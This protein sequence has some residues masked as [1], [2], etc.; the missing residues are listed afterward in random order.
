MCYSKRI[1]MSKQVNIA[2]NSIN[3][4]KVQLRVYQIQVRIFKAKQKNQIEKMDRLQNLLIQNY[5]SKLLAVSK[6]FQVIRIQSKIPDAQKFEIVFRVNVTRKKALQP[7]QIIEQSFKNFWTIQF[8]IDRAT[9]YLILFAIDPQWE[10]RFDYHILDSSLLKT[11]QDIIE[12]CCLRLQNKQ[13]RWLSKIQFEWNLNQIYP[14]ILLNKLKT[15]PQIERFVQ[16]WINQDCYKSEPVLGPLLLNILFSALDTIF[17]SYVK[18]VVFIRYMS[19]FLLFHK[20]KKILR[21]VVLRIYL[22]LQSFY[23]LINLEKSSI[24]D[25]QK[26]FRFLGFQIIQLNR[27]RQTLVK[28]WPDKIEQNKFLLTIRCKLQMNKSVSS[29]EMIQILRPIVLFWANYYQ[30]CDCQIT[31]KRLT[32]LIFQKLRAWCLRR[33]TRS[34][35][36]F[37]LDKYFPKNKIWIFNRKKYKTRW[38]LYG[39]SE[40]K[41]PQLVETFLPNVNWIQK[42][43]FIPVV[44]K[45]SLYNN[46]PYYWLLKRYRFAKYFPILPYVYQNQQGICSI[47]ALQLTPFDQVKIIYRPLR[48]KLFGKKDGVLKFRLVH[49]SCIHQKIK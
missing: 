15:L 45:L 35:K 24:L 7:R 34:S 43:I 2:W 18:D 26:G 28:I 39:R 14:S 49:Q 8:L 11:K 12:A 27:T 37:V 1:F 47:C 17:Q 16:Y 10:A 29:F 33:D 6:V 13:G 25:V 42:K 4:T 31:Y 36:T 19:Q 30:F 20:N 46:D 21:I 32:F 38:I 3:W 40:I 44:D 9:Q 5:N 41:E 48:I 22:I 23:N